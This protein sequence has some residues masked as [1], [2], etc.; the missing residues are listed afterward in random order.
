MSWAVLT[1]CAPI[2]KL[3]LAGPGQLEER[4]EVTGVPVPVQVGVQPRL[5]APRG[6]PGAVLEAQLILHLQGGWEVGGTEPGDTR[7]GDAV[8]PCP[9][10]PGGAAGPSC[11][12]SGAGTRRR[13]GRCPSGC[14]AGRT[15]QSP[16]PRGSPELRGR[17]REMQGQGTAKHR[18]LLLS[19]PQEHCWVQDRRDAPC[20]LS[21]TGELHRT[22]PCILGMRTFL[23]LESRSQLSHR[24]F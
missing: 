16:A 23:P 21:D 1:W 14:P 5:L 24:K 15:P 20:L 7:L 2:S 9:G 17:N 10:S 19:H 8:A 22:L 11:A 6:V 13:P 4:E 12:G 18:A 3:G